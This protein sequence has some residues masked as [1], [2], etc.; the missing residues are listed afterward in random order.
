VAQV[1]QVFLARA[2]DWSRIK[3]GPDNRVEEGKRELL[4]LI[5]AQDSPEG[6]IEAPVGYL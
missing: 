1:I 2:E 6:F 4:F 3:G 5:A